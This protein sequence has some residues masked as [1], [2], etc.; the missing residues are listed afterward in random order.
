MGFFKSIGK[1]LKRVVSIN[2]LTKV[3]TGNFSAVGAEILRV[4]STDKVKDPE[5]GKMVV[6]PSGK[7]IEI[8]PL[9]NDILNS[10][11]DKFGKKVVSSVAKDKTFSALTDMLT[12]A[13]IKSQWDKYKNWILGFLVSLFLFFVVKW[14]FFRKKNKRARR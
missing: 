6:V 9:V 10:E 13:G 12:K 2:T 11:G 3:A 1:K 7:K 5:T 4:A 8:S 14:A